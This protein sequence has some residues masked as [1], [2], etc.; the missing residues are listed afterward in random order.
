M[1]QIRIGIAANNEEDSLSPD[2]FLG[3]GGNENSCGNYNSGVQNIRSMGY[4]MVR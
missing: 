4:I 1:H 2:S 3:F